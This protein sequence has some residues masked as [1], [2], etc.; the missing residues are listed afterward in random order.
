MFL[1]CL[2]GG[3]GHWAGLARGAGG[4]GVRVGVYIW[5]RARVSDG[6]VIT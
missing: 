6:L 2:G 5:D 4:V 1:H 3:F